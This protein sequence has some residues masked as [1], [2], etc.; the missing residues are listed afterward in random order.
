MGVI[1][2]SCPHEIVYVRRQ[3][4]PGFPGA[5]RI[6][7]R[8]GWILISATHFLGILQIARTAQDEGG[9]DVDGDIIIAPDTIEF[10]LD[11]R[12]GM[13]SLPIVIADLGIP[14]AHRIIHTFGI[15]TSRPSGLNRYLTDEGHVQNGRTTGRDGFRQDDLQDRAVLLE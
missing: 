5:G 7:Q 6:D 14:L 9:V 2:I 11:I 4:V 13:P 15:V 8:P 10:P 12:I 1:T 3:E